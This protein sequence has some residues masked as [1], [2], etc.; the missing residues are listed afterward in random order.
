MKDKLRK[1]KAI[2]SIPSRMAFAG[3]WGLD[4]SLDLVSYHSED[5]SELGTA[6]PEGRERQGAEIRLF[7]ESAT[8]FL[9]EVD[10]RSCEEFERVMQISSAPGAR[11]TTSWAARVGRV[12]QAPEF[13][14]SWNS[15]DLIRESIAVLK[16]CWQRPLRW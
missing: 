1:D 2:G 10:D 3:G 6:P 16:E 8:R 15:S 7:S 12:T 11:R 4:L 9:V 13:R 14:V 5:D